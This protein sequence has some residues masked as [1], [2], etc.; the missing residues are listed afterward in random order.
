M[1]VLLMCFFVILFALSSPNMEEFKKV[2]QAL[3][4]HGFYSDTVP[5]E[6]PFAELRKQLVTAIS[7]SGFDTYVTASETPRGIHVEISASALFAPGSALFAP[8]AAPV[9]DMVAKQVVAVQD[10]DIT[11]DVE[12]YTDDS[13]IVSAQF[14]SNWELSS[15]RAA[16]VV[17]FL[18]EQGVPASK[19]RAVGLGDTHPKAPNRDAAGNAITANQDLNRRVVVKLLKNEDQ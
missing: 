7:A 5:V 11:I 14:P 17:R 13:A 10:R 18:I 12:G 4:E 9:L 6:D 1:S 16:S 2:A 15:A 8:Q 3:R 19:L